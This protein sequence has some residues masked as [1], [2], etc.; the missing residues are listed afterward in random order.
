[1]LLGEKNVVQIAIKLQPYRNNII[2]IYNFCKQ[3]YRLFNLE[4]LFPQDS[5]NWSVRTSA[6]TGTDEVSYRGI[7]IIVELVGFPLLQSA[8]LS[9]IHDTPPHTTSGMQ[10]AESAILHQVDGLD[11]AATLQVGASPMF[12]GNVRPRRRHRS[13]R[14]QTSLMIKY[15][16]FKART[17]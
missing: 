1:M 4:V 11:R 2:S 14:S 8:R 13:W 17:L 7:P 15:D 9:C 16:Y 3:S 6:D 12:P 10:S 5:G